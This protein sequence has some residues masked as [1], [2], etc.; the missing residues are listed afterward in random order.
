MSWKWARK[1]AGQTD[2]WRPP[3]QTTMGFERSGSQEVEYFP[4]VIRASGAGAWWF[5]FAVIG[6]GCFRALSV[7]TMLL[8]S[9]GRRKIFEGEECGCLDLSS[10]AKFLGIGLLALLRNMRHGNVRICKETWIYLND[11]SHIARW[12]AITLASRRI[13]PWSKVHVAR[14]WL[15]RGLCS[16]AWTGANKGST[17]WCCCVVLLPWTKSETLFGATNAGRYKKTTRHSDQTVFFCTSP[18]EQWI[19][20][21]CHCLLL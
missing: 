8:V 21:P 15:C 12:Q 17:P 9:R 18:C 20:H 6:E 19:V 3:G 11:I 16:L 14:R 13:S 1:K 10:I 4:E 5:Q 2:C 7:L